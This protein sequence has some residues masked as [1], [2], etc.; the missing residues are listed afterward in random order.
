MRMRAISIV[1]LVLL[2]IAAYS[3]SGKKKNKKQTIPDEQQTS[4]GPN[5]LDPNTEKKYEPKKRSRKSSKGPTFD[6]EQQ[7]YER[8]AALEKT[9]RKNERM[10][11]KPQ[12]S[13]PSYFGHK[14]PPKKRPPG[15]MKYC[16]VCGLRH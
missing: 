10:L 13:D 9:R 12:Y 11:D 7:Y 15:K 4:S 8:M 14:R 6:N 3:Q 16:K 1:I 5:T 2:S